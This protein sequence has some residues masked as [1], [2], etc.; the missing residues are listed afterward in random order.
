MFVNAKLELVAN[1]SFFD[2]F[3]ELPVFSLVYFLAL[4]LGFTGVDIRY[5]LP[6]IYKLLF[7]ALLEWSTTRLY[8]AHFLNTCIV[9]DMTNDT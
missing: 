6:G 8:N 7:E 2:L 5:L 3:P 1:V 9:I 4:C